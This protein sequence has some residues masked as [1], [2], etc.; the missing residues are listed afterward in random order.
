MSL[1]KLFS[2]LNLSMK[3]NNLPSLVVQTAGLKVYPLPP[4]FDIE[5]PERRKLR[6]YEK[7]PQY[8]PTLRAFKMQKR[9][10]YMRGEEQTHN[11]LLHKQFGVVAQMGGRLKHGHF[12]MMRF[13]VARKLPETCFAI[14]RVDPPWQPIS[15][16]A[17]GMGMGGGKGAIDHYV[18]PIKAGRVI[19]EVGGPVEYK[20]VKTQLEEIAHKLPFKA[21]AVSYESMQAMAEKEKRMEA[22][23]QNPWTLKYIIQ[24]N[25]GG[26]ANWISPVDRK[27]FG[28]HR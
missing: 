16:K 27:W 6:I 8:P 24:N 7:V 20:E 15:K 28:K 4:K 23:N 10:R 1:T 19:M 11:F 9:L 12:E 13:V 5:Y 18:T 21:I 25:L 26:C 3:I 2:R 14:Y 22:E 17:Q